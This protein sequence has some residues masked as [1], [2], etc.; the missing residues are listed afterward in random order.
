MQRRIHLLLSLVQS[1]AALGTARDECIATIGG[2]RVVTASEY[3]Y[4]LEDLQTAKAKL[5]ELDRLSEKLQETEHK[6]KSLEKAVDQ[7]FQWIQPPKCVHPDGKYLQYDGESWFCVCQD[8]SKG[9]SCEPALEDEPDLEPTASEPSNRP[10]ESIASCEADPLLDP[11]RSAVKD[12]PAIIEAKNTGEPAVIETRGT[13]KPAISQGQAPASSIITVLGMS[14]FGRSA[15]RSGG[16]DYAYK[17]LVATMEECQES[18]LSQARCL[19]CDV[20]NNPRIGPT[21]RASCYLYTH[22]ADTH[23]PSKKYLCWNKVV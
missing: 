15:C 1:L 9:G 21:D 13:G 10:G 4:L 7:R 22:A 8:G 18:C 12:E 20:A 2:E 14:F 23:S 3:N 11:L 6:L 19:A 16:R 17:N 5:R